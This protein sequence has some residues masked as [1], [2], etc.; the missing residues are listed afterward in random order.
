[1]HPKT[2]LLAAFITLTCTAALHAAD[3]NPSP[4]SNPPIV[5]RAEE[6]QTK[7]SD[8]AS[9]EKMHKW[10]NF[11]LGIQDDSH[12]TSEQKSRRSD[13]TNETSPVISE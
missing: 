12:D 11:L 9:A 4:A 8:T 2:R 7:P 3:H 6:E 10:K 5:A 13:I 1:M